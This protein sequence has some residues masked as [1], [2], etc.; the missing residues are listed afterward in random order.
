MVFG[1]FKDEA[2]QLDELA[3]RI[4]QQALQLGLYGPDG[5]A[6]RGSLGNLASKA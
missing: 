2:Q 4:D 5:Q 3:T 6:R 1:Q